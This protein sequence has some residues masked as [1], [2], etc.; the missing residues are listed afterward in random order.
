[1]IVQFNLIDHNNSVI[2][3]KFWNTNTDLA[4]VLADVAVMAPLLQ[5]IVQGGLQDVTISTEDSS[6]AFAVSAEESNIDEGMT[7][8]VLGGDG[9]NYPLKVPMPRSDLRLPGRAIA[10]NDADLVAFLAKF[11]GGAGNDWRIN[12]RNPTTVVSVNSGKLDK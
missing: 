12:L 2:R 5:A 11:D 8:S 9:F 10:L 3:K 1:M 7:L 4:T 6:D